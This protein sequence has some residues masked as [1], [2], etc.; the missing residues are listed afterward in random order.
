MKILSW[1]LLVGTIVVSIAATA[2]G[3]IDNISYV[4]YLSE[5]ALLFA[6]VVAVRQNSTPREVV[7]EVINKTEIN[8]VE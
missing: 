2:F 4:S 1:S 7:A 8:E 3:F 5:V 6:A